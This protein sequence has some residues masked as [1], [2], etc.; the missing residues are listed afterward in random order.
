MEKPPETPESLVAQQHD[1]LVRHLNRAVVFAV[2][3]LA[4]LITL[5]IFW[6]VI[7]VIAHLYLQ[8]TKGIAGIFYAENLV[9]IL[10]SFL[11]VMI[12]IEVFLN[13]VF[14]L[15]KDALHVQLVLAT[16]L[17][18]VARKVIVFDYSSSPPNI[19]MPQQ[20]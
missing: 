17:T 4:V 19:S 6:G 14:Y 11:V 13:I 18:A 8:F 9:S 10:G 20:P 1:W 7:D 15:K 5:V 12:A 3:I 16:A 2:K